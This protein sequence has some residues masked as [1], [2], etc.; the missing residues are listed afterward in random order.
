LPL[1]GSVKDTTGSFAPIFVLVGL[2]PF[3]GLGALL[4]GWKEQ[5]EEAKS[6]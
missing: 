4:L 2:L 5:P 3:V 6:S 1:A